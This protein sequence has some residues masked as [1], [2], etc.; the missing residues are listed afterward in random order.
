MRV[1]PGQPHPLGAHWDG[2]GTNFALA[3]AEATAVRLCLFDDV[4]G[5]KAT[6]EIPLGHHTHGVWHAYL[7]DVRPGQLYGYRAEGP[8]IPAEGLRF[9]PA[10]LLVDPYALALTGG[11]AWDGALFEQPRTAEPD[12]RD[13]AP[14]VPRGVVVDPSF[15]WGDD[16]PPRTPWNRSLIYECHVKGLTQLHPHVPEDQRG[17]YLGLAA[18]PVLH[19]LHELGVTAVELLPVHHSV[20]E[21]A[22]ARRGLVNYWGYN[23]LG[24][25]APDARFAS[26]DRGEQVA[27][28]KTLVRALHQ[29]GI[30]VLL[31]VV[32]NHTAEGGPGGPTLSWRGL[33]DR[34]VYHRDAH[35]PARYADYT[36][37]GNT[38]NGSDP[39]VLQLILDSMRYFVSEMHVDGFRLDLAP[40]LARRRGRQPGPPPASSRSSPRTPC[41]PRSSSSPSPGT[42]APTAI[43]SAASPPSGRSGTTSIGTPCGASG[44][45][46]RACWARLHRPSPGARHIFEQGDRTPAAS[47][48]YVTSHDGFTLHDLV[49]FEKKHNEAN[50][51][52]N[53][54][55]TDANHARNW[56]A[57]G[58]SDSDRIEHL[59]QRVT[60]SL[61]TTLA[62]SQGVPMFLHGD[63]MGRSQGGN[64]NGYCQDNATTWVDWD[65]GDEARDLLEF[66]RSLFALRKRS[67]LLRRTQ[68]FSGD[69]HPERGERDVIWLRPDGKEMEPPDWKGNDHVLGMLIP[70]EANPEEDDQGQPVPAETLLLIFNAEDRAVRFHR[71]RH[72]RPGVWHHTFCSAGSHQRRLR[73]GSVR[74]PPHSVTV[75][76][77]REPR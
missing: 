23:T 9:N 34:T 17:R 42:W 6:H 19:H 38:L 69:L 32:Y 36:G 8:W 26:R 57:E 7:P 73:H 50:G 28:F 15:P 4:E 22:L 70:R 51:E 54:D 48:N 21:Q 3:C 74:V 47:I 71:P 75:L 30:E 72:S 77:Y 44:A 67:P 33:D 20:S 14:C 1:W 2:R 56:G 45:A 63:E 76:T 43:G 29:A 65:L 62:V 40:A 59:R 25:F 64:N 39:R 41:W 49:R 12:P 60:R 13:S 58:P 55:G 68:F 53:R 61:I 66:T 24:F 27:E 37:C 11:V 46:T 31:D 10:K 16:R 5:S 18:D 35:D 52:D